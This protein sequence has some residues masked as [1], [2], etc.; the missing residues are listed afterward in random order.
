MGFGVWGLGFG[1]W[2]LGFGVG[3]LGFGGLGVWGFGGLGVWGFGGLGVWGLGF[4]VWGLGFGAWGLGFGVW[5]LGF[6]S[7][8][9]NSIAKHRTEHQALTLSRRHY[10]ATSGK[11]TGVSGNRAL[12]LTEHMCL[13]REPADKIHRNSIKPA[14]LLGDQG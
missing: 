11:N 2:G 9:Q 1:V 5:G 6:A 14:M 13:S 4:G 3:G 8:G 7:Q 12:T 10:Q